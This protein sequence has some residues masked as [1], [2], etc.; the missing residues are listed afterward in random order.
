MVMMAGLS[1]ALRGIGGDY[2]LNRIVGAFG[3]FTYIVGAHGFVI[4]NMANGNDF[5]LIA[6]CA[7]FPAGLGVVVGAIAGAVAIKDR[8][9]ASAKA[10]EQA[11][12]RA[13]GETI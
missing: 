10:I 7:A 9:V 12:D 11:G 5:D 4:W 1:H 8:N 3:G 13:A 2:E 6:Y